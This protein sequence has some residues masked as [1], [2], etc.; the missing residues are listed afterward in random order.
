MFCRKLAN[1]HWLVKLTLL[2]DPE[3]ISELRPTHEIV[4]LDA[5]TKTKVECQARV[6][7]TKLI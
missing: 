4:H 6:E 1:Y 3:M 7:R 2:I 5:R